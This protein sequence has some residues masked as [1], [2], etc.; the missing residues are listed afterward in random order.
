MPVRSFKNKL[1]NYTWSINDLVNCESKNIVYFIQYNKEN[2]K[3]NKYVDE[4]ERDLGERISERRGYIHRKETNQTT[5]ERFNKPGHLIKNMKTTILEKVKSTD[6][7]Y[8]KER[9]NNTLGS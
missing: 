5:G 9:K 1:G 2:C 6:P 7:I 3:E 8:R 4:S